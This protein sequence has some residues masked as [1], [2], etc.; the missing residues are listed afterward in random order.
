MA[1]RKTTEEFIKEA[2]EVHGDRYDYTLAEYVSARKKIKI[3][4]D[5]HGVFEQTP[6][7][8]LKGK[9]CAKCHGF[10]KTNNDIIN[11][12]KE[13]HGDKY[14]YREVEY[15][16]ARTPVK[17]I[18]PDHGVFEQTSYNHLSGRGCIKCSGK[19]ISTTEEFIERSK[20]IHGDKYDYRLVNYKRSNIKVRIICKEHG[21]F[22]QVPNSHVSG[23]GCYKCGIEL[24]AKKSKENP[25][26]WGAES[27]YNKSEN[28][29][30]FDSFKVYI[31]KC[32][33]D[34]ETF[35]KIGRTFKSIKKRFKSKKD[36]PYSYDIIKEI[37]FY[38]AKD[39][40]DK[41]AELK[42]L[43]RR[44]KYIPSISFNGKHEC[45]SKEPIY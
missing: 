24:I 32:W 17:I 21:F 3:L 19:L 45:F 29:K 4:C 34:S 37:V 27:W 35:Y 26:G 33:N 20:L 14:D 7:N 6:D 16:N 5:L 38:N 11:K 18:C 25:M 22:D 39:A 43:N 36:M 23:S 30:N 42:R 1:R 41:E 28:S 8:H 40:F 10:N 12:F 31:I 9:N 2:K 13:I 44:F 15:Y